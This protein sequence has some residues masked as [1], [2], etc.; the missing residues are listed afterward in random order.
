MLE[1]PPP[2]VAPSSEAPPEKEIKE[3]SVDLLA[4]E[5]TPAPPKAEVGVQSDST[6]KVVYIENRYIKA[7]L[8][9]QES[10]S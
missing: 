6:A 2:T 4:A 10:K 1:P 5:S 9:Q 7:A 8:K 3:K